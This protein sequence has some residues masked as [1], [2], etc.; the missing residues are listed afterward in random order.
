MS[1]AMLNPTLFGR[2]NAFSRRRWD[3]AVESKFVDR[4]T[5]SPA[6]IVDTDAQGKMVVLRQGSNGFTC[7]PGHLLS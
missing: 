6:W 5:T 3:N 1:V 7:M 4:Y 2:W